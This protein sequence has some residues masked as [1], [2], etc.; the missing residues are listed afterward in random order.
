MMLRTDRNGR[1]GR[2]AGNS[3]NTAAH[4]AVG[5]STYLDKR[6]THAESLVLHSVSRTSRYPGLCKLQRRLHAGFAPAPKSLL[7]PRTIG[8]SG[9]R[10]RFFYG[11]NPRKEILA[12]ILLINAKA[13]APC[14]DT[15]SP[16]PPLLSAPSGLQAKPMP[17]GQFSPGKKHTIC[18]GC[19][20]HDDTIGQKLVKQV[21]G[22][23]YRVYEKKVI[24]KIQNN[25]I[26]ICVHRSECYPSK[27][28]KL[29]IV[30]PVN[31]S[32]YSRIGNISVF[33]STIDNNRRAALSAAN[34]K[35]HHSDVDI[36]AGDGFVDLESTSTVPTGSAALKPD[37]GL[38]A[39][40]RSIKFH[41]PAAWSV[42]E[43]DFSSA[44]SLGPLFHPHSEKRAWMRRG[45]DAMQ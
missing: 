2:S 1:V 19:P 45:C 32:S 33:A 8:C 25:S 21:H 30:T 23:D 43:A 39:W 7:C 31:P 34:L 14:V 15:K 42:L 10:D 6:A 40:P 4:R 16:H 37:F 44:L 35:K 41:L 24:K 36:V 18:H 5:I 29:P 3:G 26:A 11:C 12:H 9:R 17:G 22:K 13:A 38:T 20:R 28:Q 27:K